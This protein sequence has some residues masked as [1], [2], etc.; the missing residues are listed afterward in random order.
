MENT[1][2]ENIPISNS[3]VYKILRNKTHI[4]NVDEIFKYLDDNKIKSLYPLDDLR[5]LKKTAKLNADI[6]KL[7]MVS[8]TNCINILDEEDILVINKHFNI[9]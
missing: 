4:G 5:N 2:S 3:E 1:Q 9:S 6:L 7:A 8:N